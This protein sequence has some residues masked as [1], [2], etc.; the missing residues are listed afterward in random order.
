MTIDKSRLIITDVDITINSIEEL[1]K[2]VRICH[3]RTPLITAKAVKH[4]ELSL[5]KGDTDKESYNK[6][7]VQI[8]DLSSKFEKE[9]ICGIV[10]RK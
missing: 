8:N 7:N 10:Y 5:Y 3:P 9:C 1:D 6:R 2:M 4:N